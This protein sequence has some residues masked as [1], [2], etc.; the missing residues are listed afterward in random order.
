MKKFKPL[1]LVMALVAIVMTVVACSSTANA[2]ESYVTID[3]NPSVELIVNEREKVVYVNALNE[4]AEVLLADLNLVGMPVD[5]ATDL[6][7][8]TAIALG[9]ID[10]EASDTVV[11]VSST[12]DTA[13]G[14]QI[15]ERVKVAVNEAF[16]NRGVYGRAKDKGFTPDFIAEAESYGVTPGFL[17]LAQSVVAVQDDITLEDALLMTQEDLR[18]ILKDAK[19]AAKDVI[20]DLRDAFFT[21]REEIRD[22]YAPTLEQLH[23]D[24]ALLNTQIADVEAQIE[25]ESTEE[26]VAQLASLQA[27]LAD[28]QAQ[29]EET[30]QDMQ[31][32]IAVLRDQF[33][34]DSQALRVELMTRMNTRRSQFQNRV[35]QWM[36]NHQGNQYKEDIEAYQN[37]Y[38]QDNGSENGQNGGK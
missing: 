34:E 17:F 2:E 26:L 3:I 1:L 15:R 37:S 30:I 21:A 18:D 29:L 33:H 24:I 12:S 32:E 38:Q 11:E 10:V 19:E 6:I 8:E 7:I 25:V 4:D 27:N 14:E 35:N 23:T 31:D 5:E 28:L 36:Q 16:Q 9:Y 13:L 20:A 22:T